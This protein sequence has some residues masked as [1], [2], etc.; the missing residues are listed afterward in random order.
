MTRAL[1]EY[2]TEE[3]ALFYGASWCPALSGAEETLRGVGK[4]SPVHRMQP[5]WPQHPAGAVMHRASVRSYPT[6]VINGRT[7]AGEVLSLAQLAAAVGFPEA[8]DF[9]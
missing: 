9:K 7:I 2:L 3:G 8:A 5:R 1:A 6:W 4:P